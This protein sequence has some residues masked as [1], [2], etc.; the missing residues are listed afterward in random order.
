MKLIPSAIVRTGILGYT[1]SVQ[2]DC[3][4]DCEI[5]IPND[6]EINILYAY[7]LLFEFLSLL[8]YLSCKNNFDGYMSVPVIKIDRRVIRASH[9]TGRL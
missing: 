6:F 7:R 8:C 9:V 3:E 1:N 4:L 5:Q 2:S